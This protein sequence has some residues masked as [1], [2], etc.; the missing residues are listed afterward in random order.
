MNSRKWKWVVILML[1]VVLAGCFGG[2]APATEEPLPQEIA[3]EEGFQTEP[4]SVAP[5]EEGEEAALETEAPAE[6]LNEPMTYL[7]SPQSNATVPANQVYIQGS[8]TAEGQTIHVRIVDINTTV[9][10]DGDIPIIGK[11]FETT[12]DATAQQPV[13]VTTPADIEVYQLDAMNNPIAYVKTTV[14]LQPVATPQPTAAPTFPPP[15]GEAGDVFP[16]DFTLTYPK[17]GGRV[18]FP[19]HMAGYLRSSQVRDVNI[20]LQYDTGQ[21]AATGQ[22]TPWGEITVFI[23]NLTGTNAPATTPA[24][25]TLRDASTGIALV[26]RELTLVGT[27]E[28]ASVTAY[29]FTRGTANL[30]PVQRYVPLARAGSNAALA[31]LFWGLTLQEQSTLQTYIPTPQEIYTYAPGSPPQN[32]LVHVRDSHV[33]SGG[34]AMVTLSDTLLAVPTQNQAQAARQIQQTLLQFDNVK[35][36]AIAVGGTLWRPESDI[37]SAPQPT[38]APLPTLTPSQPDV[39]IEPVINLTTPQNGDMVSSGF[40]TAGEATVPRPGEKLQM[41]LTIPAGTIFS[42][43][44]NIIGAEVGQLGVLDTRVDYAGVT[45]P[46][47]AILTVSYLDRTGA[48]AL[49][50]SRNITLNPSP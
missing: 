5:L 18:T 28:A 22:T 13:L 46:T 23:Y 27:N 6:A 14:T 41:E 45:E 20:L 12:V 26:E 3:P 38:A 7:Q 42:E 49:Q 50:E 8:T 1:G 47:S 4:E 37:G 24:T 36:V 17:A 2:T 39:P 25:L 10:F 15:T 35:D 48:V 16:P 32:A 11:S 19:L 29:F 43:S 9:R 21:A 30:Q 34:V 40:V 33:N 44:L 31:E